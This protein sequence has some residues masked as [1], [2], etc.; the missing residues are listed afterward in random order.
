MSTEK[1]IGDIKNEFSMDKGKGETSC[2]ELGDLEWI[3]LAQIRLVCDSCVVVLF[4]LPG[5][6]WCTLR[7]R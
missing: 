3:L 2:V 6:C 7:P 5:G 4:L 1:V